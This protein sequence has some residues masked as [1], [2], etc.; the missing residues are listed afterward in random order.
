MKKIK[1]YEKV[2]VYTINFNCCCKGCSWWNVISIDVAKALLKEVGSG[3]TDAQIIAA[4]NKAGFTKD[5]D[6]I[7]KK[8]R[9]IK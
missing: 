2:L 6:L 3:H 9:R 1:N 7:L 5:T 8:Y 4:L